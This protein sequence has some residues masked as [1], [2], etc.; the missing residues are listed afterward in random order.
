M[1]LGKILVRKRLI[2]HIQLNTALEIQSLTGIKLGEI[3]VTKELIESQDLE[4]ALL[5]QYWRKKGF[6]VID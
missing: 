5:E 3:L 4:Q 1:Q 2:S 6:W